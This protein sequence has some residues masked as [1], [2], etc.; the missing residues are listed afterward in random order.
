M[1]VVGQEWLNTTCGRD[2]GALP[3]TDGQE[4]ALADVSGVAGHVCATSI[5]C[6]RDRV[7]L[8]GILGPTTLRH[9]EEN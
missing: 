9:R 2:R 5:S 6:S 3:K 1:S 4:V 8:T 7:F